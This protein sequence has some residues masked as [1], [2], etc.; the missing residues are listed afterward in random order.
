MGGRVAVGRGGGRNAA[1]GGGSGCAGARFRA[2]QALSA[3]GGGV[4]SPWV[5]MCRDWPLFVCARG[6]LREDRV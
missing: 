4:A 2:S 6:G 5:Y 1:V 3:R